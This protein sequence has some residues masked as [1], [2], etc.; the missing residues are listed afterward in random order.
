MDSGGPA[1][2]LQ[3]SLWVDAFGDC[4]V[5]SDNNKILTHPANERFNNPKCLQFPHAKQ[6]RPLLPANLK[7][8]TPVFSLRFSILLP[9][10]HTEAVLVF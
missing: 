6:N 10:Y 4:P 1:C 5:L 7:I 2:P 8:Y 9:F 3:M